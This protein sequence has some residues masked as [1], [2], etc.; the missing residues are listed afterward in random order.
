M[1]APRESAFVALG[2]NVGDRGAHLALA[3][4]RL[5]AL[6]DTRLAAASAI[7]ETAAVGPVEQ[8]AF[9]NQMVLLETGLTPH[10]LLDAGLAI[11]RE[12]GRVRRERWGPR[13][14]DIDIVRFG[15]RRIA[16]A[17]LTVPHPELKNRPFWQRE[18]EELE[19]HAR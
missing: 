5:A 7:E 10:A 17:R 15:E 1:T 8:P 12:A 16:D 2:S 14:L 11:E 6:P 19:A 4:R 18:L 9:L 3:R 13:T